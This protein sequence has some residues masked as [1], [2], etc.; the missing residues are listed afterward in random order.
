MQ[1]KNRHGSLK[2]TECFRV[3]FS[4][5]LRFLNLISWKQV[6]AADAESS[7]CHAASRA[8]CTD[9]QKYGQSGR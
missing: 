4:N 7:A 3:F 5:V 2:Y 9:M 1:H 8:S 6:S